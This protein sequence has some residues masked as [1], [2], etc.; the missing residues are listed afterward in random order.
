M[1][2]PKEL[3]NEL[4]TGNDVFSSEKGRELS[5]FQKDQSPFA[6]VVMCSDSRI[7]SRFCNIETTNKFFIIRNIGNQVTTA[8]GS[9]DYGVLHLRTPLL[10]ILGHSD[11]GAIKASLSDYSGETSGIKRELDTLQDPVKHTCNEEDLEN[12]RCK[13]IQKNVDNQVSLCMTKYKDLVE[14]NK[15]VIIGAMFDFH[16]MFSEKLGKFHILN[17]NGKTDTEDVK[18]MDMFNLNNFK[19]FN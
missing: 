8:E 4:I 2:S 17:I 10:I 18:T 19:R 15:L 11:C 12:R 14:Q 9:V 16:N 6:T 3:L 7:S 5:E 1:K 13:C